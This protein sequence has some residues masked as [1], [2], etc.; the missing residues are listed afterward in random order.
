MEKSQRE[1]VLFLYFLIVF[2]LLPLHGVLAEDFPSI[3]AFRIE[4]NIIFIAFRFR[5][6]LLFYC[7]CRACR[8]PKHLFIHLRE[9]AK[10]ILSHI[11]SSFQT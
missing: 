1:K 10:A 7:R 4:I 11:V 3:D 5:G 9:P 2:L 6:D 8:Y